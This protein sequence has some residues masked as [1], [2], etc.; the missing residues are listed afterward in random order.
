M[1]S[2]LPQS[3]VTVIVELRRTGFSIREIARRLGV[4]RETIG[5][6]LNRLETEISTG[7]ESLF[8]VDFEI[9]PSSAKRPGPPSCCE[10]FR[11]LI[12]EKVHQ[13]WSARMIHQ[14]LVREH[15]FMARYHSVRRYVAKFLD[16]TKPQSAVTPVPL[17]PPD[18][19]HH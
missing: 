18:V 17:S 14:H 13:G 3:T 12:I 8:P 1:A 5:K 16:G 15:A 11:D 10:P 19:P 6:Y 2:P 4:H 9:S 7:R